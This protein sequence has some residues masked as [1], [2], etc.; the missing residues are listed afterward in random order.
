MGLCELLILAVGLSMDAFAVSV[1]KGL[2]LQKISVKNMLTVG[3]WFGA[4]Q[5]LMPCFGY[6]GSV[7]FAV[8]FQRFSHWIAC[9]LLAFIGS[10][11]IYEAM[12]AEC[13]IDRSM[14]VRTMFILAVAT[15]IDALAVGVSFAVLAVNLWQAAA[16]IGV[17]TF[18]FSVVGIKIGSIFGAK[19]HRVSEITG[20]VILICIGLKILAEGLGMLP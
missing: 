18:L 11:M 4:F 15:S 5:A 3:L 2:S 1:C 16:L 14:G 10:K 8:Y 7:M 17:V 20:G 13:E 9:G 6:F 19:W 12:H